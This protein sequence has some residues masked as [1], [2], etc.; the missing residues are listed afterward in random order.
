MSSEI[1]LDVRELAAPEPLQRV[2]AALPELVSGQ[3]LH[4]LHRREAHCLR[5]TL[6][7]LGF[8]HAVDDK[9]DGEFDIWIW[10]AKD[11][12]AA[13]AVQRQRRQ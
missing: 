3:F 13:L 1:L 6:S 12:L 2:M 8:D 9:G 11:E 4:L 10:P 7:S 5:E